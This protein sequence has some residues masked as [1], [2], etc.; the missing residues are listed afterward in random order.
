M[1]VKKTLEIG[2]SDTK[3]KILKFSIDDVR[4]NITKSDLTSIE[5]AI[6]DSKVFKGTEGDLLKLENA[7]YRELTTTDLLK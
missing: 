2:F 1:A 6:I 3:G 5:H 7:H 4:D